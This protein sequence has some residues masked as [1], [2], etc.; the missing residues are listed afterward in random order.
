MPAATGHDVRVT[1]L[2]EDNG[3]SNS[4]SD[5]NHKTFGANVRFNRAEASNDPTKLFDPNDREA[6]QIIA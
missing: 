3:F 4:P 5:S 2:W 6:A 1:Y